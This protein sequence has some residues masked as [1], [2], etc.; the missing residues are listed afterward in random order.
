MISK[1][2]QPFCKLESYLNDQFT[3]SG[4]GLFLIYWK[5][6]QYSHKYLFRPQSG[7]LLPEL[8]MGAL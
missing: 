1:W 8:T 2:R 4:I 3:N 6:H 7:D 5:N